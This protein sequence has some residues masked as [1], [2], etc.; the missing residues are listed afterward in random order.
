M[1]G[2]LDQSANCIPTAHSVF[3]STNQHALTMHKVSLDSTGRGNCVYNHFH[4]TYKLGKMPVADLDSRSQQE[5]KEVNANSYH[6]HRHAKIIM[7]QAPLFSTNILSSSLQFLLH[8]VKYIE[9]KLVMTLK[10]RE[11]GMAPGKLS[12]TQ[13]GQIIYC[14]NDVINVFLH[15]FKCHWIILF[16][17]AFLQF[18]I[19]ANAGLV[20]DFL[21]LW[22]LNQEENIMLPSATSMLSNTFF[23]NSLCLLSKGRRGCLSES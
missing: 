5:K 13:Q 23:T 1:C 6:I 21:I 12:P 18:F 3:E 7:K 22:T 9:H 11:P 8:N 20:K 2:V 10:Q 15:S 4:L 14:I 17:I 19:S 16:M